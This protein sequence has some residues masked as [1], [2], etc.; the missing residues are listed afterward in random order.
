ML[1][2]HLPSFQRH[3]LLLTTMSFP[4]QITPPAAPATPLTI[5]ETKDDDA[6]AG[7]GCRVEV[8]DAI[9]GF[10]TCAGGCIEGMLTMG[11]VACE[12]CGVGR[13][14]VTD[15]AGGAACPE[16]LSRGETERLDWC[17]GEKVLSPNEMTGP[18]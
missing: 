2:Q 12:G 14:V 16:S 6:G 9:G 11:R 8:G 15:A 17:V 10:C 18:C 7:C 5:S 1:S 13:G 3:T 4:T